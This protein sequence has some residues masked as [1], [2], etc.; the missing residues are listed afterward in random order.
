MTAKKAIWNQNSGTIFPRINND[1]TLPQNIKYNELGMN[2]S[3]S[4]TKIN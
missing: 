4:R 2:A 3:F 1:A